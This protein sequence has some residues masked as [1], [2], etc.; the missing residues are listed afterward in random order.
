M[1]EEDL[2]FA[3]SMSKLGNGRVSQEEVLIILL[4][5]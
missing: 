4:R 3:L 5:K 1:E 2:A